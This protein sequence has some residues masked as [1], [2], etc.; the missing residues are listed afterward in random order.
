[1]V[2]PHTILKVILARTPPHRGASSPRVC[3]TSRHLAV[4]RVSSPKNRG[5]VTRDFLWYFESSARSGFDPHGYGESAT[6]VHRIRYTRGQ[7]AAGP[8]PYVISRRFLR[9]MR[10]LELLSAGRLWKTLRPRSARYIALR[11]RPVRTKNVDRR[12]RAVLLRVPGFIHHPGRARRVVFRGLS[13]ELWTRGL[14]LDSRPDTRIGRILADSIPASRGH[15]PTLGAF[16]PRRASSPETISF[17]DRYY[18]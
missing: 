1:M 12:A 10:L 3:G 17:G 7:H 18:R 6:T 16:A 8:V 5:H 11:V 2:F 9:N 14:E 4:A 13:S 15:G